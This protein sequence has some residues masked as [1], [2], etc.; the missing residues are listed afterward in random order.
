MSITFKINVTEK[1]LVNFIASEYRKGSG[2][3]VHLFQS[4]ETRTLGIC[5]E[6]GGLFFNGAKQ[7][8]AWGNNNPLPMIKALKRCG[9]I[10]KPTWN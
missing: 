10:F 7:M 3:P 1:A 9:V 4:I 6:V 5:D 8:T 2:L